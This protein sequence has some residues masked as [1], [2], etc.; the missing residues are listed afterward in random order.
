MDKVKKP[1]NPECREPSPG[2]FRFQPFY[3]PKLSGVSAAPTSKVRRSAILLL[4]SVEN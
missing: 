1:S 4:L 3:D 2:P